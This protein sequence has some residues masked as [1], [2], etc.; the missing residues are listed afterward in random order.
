MGKPGADGDHDVGGMRP[1]CF[2]HPTH[3]AGFA[4]DDGVTH[5][6]EVGVRADYAAFGTDLKPIAD[7]DGF[8]RMHFLSAL[9]GYLDHRQMEIDW[10]AARDAPCEALVASLAMALPVANAEKQA[11]L[12]AGTMADRRRALITLMEIDA[13]E[14]DEPPLQ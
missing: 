2:L 10:E 12:E 13:A 14:D 11:L 7:D 5:V 9:K 4:V 8:D 6:H 1:E 3:E